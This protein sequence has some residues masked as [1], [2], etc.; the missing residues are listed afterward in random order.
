MLYK[1][2]LSV[3]YKFHFFFKFGLLFVAFSNLSS[4]HLLI[5]PFFNVILPLTLLLATPCIGLHNYIPNNWSVKIISYISV[6]SIQISGEVDG[7]QKW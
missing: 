1:F 2:H 5:L 6:I 3:L 7:T 4:S